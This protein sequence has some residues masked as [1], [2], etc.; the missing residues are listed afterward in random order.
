MGNR[1]LN[2]LAGVCGLAVAIGFSAVKAQDRATS[3]PR[4]EASAATYA[5]PEGKAPAGRPYFVEFRAR[6]AYNYGHAFVVHGRVGQTLTPKDV[7]GLHPRGESPVPWML[8]HL[9]P[10]PSETGWSDGDVG[11]NDYYI[12]AKYRI[13]LTEAEYRVVLAKMRDMQASSPVWSATLYNCV[14]FVGDIAAFMGLE[15]PFRWVMPK[16]YVEGIKEMNG[17]HQQLPSRW[18][19]TVDPRYA[20]AAQQV[21]ASAR[22]HPS[23][24]IGHPVPQTDA[25]PAPRQQSAPSATTRSS[26]SGT[27][28]RRPVEA[29]RPVA[30][31]S[32]ATAQ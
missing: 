7:V 1:I 20:A 2:I 16:E 21:R 8:G 31:S 5:K 15:H 24:Q 11:Y 9:V 4:H 32:Y 27:T 17:G 13:Y 19:E 14:A 23:V 30:Q 18:L 26:S 3:E 28:T 6:A 29:P 10:V 22:P 25:Q 12:T